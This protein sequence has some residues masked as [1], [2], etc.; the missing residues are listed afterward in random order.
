M[1]GP[2]DVAASLTLSS[3]K[4]IGVAGYA[5]LVERFGTADAVL[6]AGAERLSSEGDVSPA[7]ARVIGT[8]RPSRD[9]K[10]LM[11]WAAASGVR[12]LPLEHPEYPARLR[13]IADPPSLLYVKGDGL[14]RAGRTV[15]VVGSRWMSSYGKQVTGD[16]CRAF[17]DAGITV[18]SGM[19]LG[20]DGYAHHT[21]LEAEGNT[22]AVLGTGLDLAY[23]P[24]HRDLF[25]ALVEKGAVISEYPPGTRPV[26]HNFPR[27][28]R[29]ISGLCMG[30]VVVEARKNSGSLITARLAAEQGREVYAVPGNVGQPGAYGTNRL[31]QEGASLVTGPLDVIGDLLPQLAGEAGGRAACAEKAFLAGLPEIQRRILGHLDSVPVPVDDLAE[32]VGAPVAALLTELLTLELT[33]LVE[34]LPGN[35]YIRHPSSG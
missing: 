33:G 28:N 3:L 32:R 30:V 34:K 6:S 16:F 15:A 20:V 4:G 23:P 11:D 29:I 10:R 7:L 5:R 1:S 9:G 26:G 12:M 31:I 27:R 8:A 24:E 2:V 19:A 17:V 14:A 22:V 13:E 25:S 35:R 18:V 21:T